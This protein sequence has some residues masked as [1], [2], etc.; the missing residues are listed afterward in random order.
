MCSHVGHEVTYCRVVCPVG[1]LIQRTTSFVIMLRKTRRM[2][3]N[4]IDVFNSSEKLTKS[5]VEGMMFFA[6]ANNDRH[7]DDFFFD[8]SVVIEII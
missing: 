5:K 6:L 7:L 2:S 3:L 4:E 1:R 8:D